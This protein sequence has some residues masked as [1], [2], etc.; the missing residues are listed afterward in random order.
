M[1]RPNLKVADVLNLE[2]DSLINLSSNSW[3]YRTLMAITRCRTSEMGSHIDKCTSCD[4]IHIS[5]NSCRNRH[6]PTCQG[7]KTKQWINARVKELLPTSYFHVV[8]TIPHELNPFCLRCSKEIYATLFKTAWETLKQFSQNPKHLGADMGMIGVLHTWGQNLSLHPH[9]H[10]II[11]GGGVTKNGDWKQVKSKGKYLF[12]VKAMSIVFRAKFVAELRKQK[13]KI[14]QSVY[15]LLFKKEWVVYA[16]PAFGT[17]KSIVEYLGRYTH[18]IA[19]SNYRIL[20]INKEKRTVKF[21][22]KNYKNGG[23]KT[24]LILDSKEFIRRF[25]LHILPKGF[26]RLRHFGILSSSWKKDKLP[27]LQAQLGVVKQV[28]KEKIEKNVFKKCPKCKVGDLV[29]IVVS[30]NKGPPPKYRYLIK[31]RNFKTLV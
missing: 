5:Y 21:S 6:C 2:R 30:D 25:S 26:T 27:K 16:K 10:C 12:N 3:K 20:T 29:T 28:V 18:K 13:L 9:L 23:T 24:T 1:K 15:D 19:I 7:H 22:L 8:F 11:P 17:A 4:S 31:D 14:P